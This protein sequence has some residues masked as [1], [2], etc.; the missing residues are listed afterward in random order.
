MQKKLLIKLNVYMKLFVF[1]KSLDILVAELSSSLEE[2]IK[3][4]DNLEIKNK[5]QF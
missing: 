5:K 2:D 3:E 4:L 1:L